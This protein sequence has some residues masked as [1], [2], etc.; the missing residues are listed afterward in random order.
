MK[1]EEWRR[2][3]KNCYCEPRTCELRT[4]IPFCL[5]VGGDFGQDAGFLIDLVADGNFLNA[6]SFE[7]VYV[8]EGIDMATSREGCA[9]ISLNELAE[10][11]QVRTSFRMFTVN[12]CEVKVSKPE[13]QAGLDLHR[14]GDT[15]LMGKALVG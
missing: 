15:A 11:A 12:V 2:N 9:R 14:K 10:K 8:F 3:L 5:V 6:D 7:I 4:L 13:R 1:G